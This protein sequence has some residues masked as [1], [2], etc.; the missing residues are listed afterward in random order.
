MV[1]NSIT[2]AVLKD[3]K[4]L[5]RIDVNCSVKNGKII[6][7]DRLKA[8]AETIKFLINKK[9]RVVVLAHQGSPDKD[10]FISLKQHSKILNKYVKLKFVSELVGEKS[11]QEINSLKSG[12]ALL[13]ENVRF[14][15]DE[16]KPSLNNS[17]SIFFKEVGFDYYVNDAFSVSHRNQTSI[18]SL[19]QIFPGLM[20]LNLEKEINNL[21]QLRKL[22]KSSLFILGGVKLEDI[23]LLLN[24][25]KILS[26]GRLA[27][28]AL[29]VKGYDLGKHNQVTKKE[30]D[31]VK[32]YIKNITLPLDLAI[33]FNG[34]RKEIDVKDLPANGKILDL[35]MKTLES[36]KKEITKSKAIFFKGA[37]GRIEQNGFDIG[38]RMI[39][40]AISNSK[41]FSVIS[42]GSSLDSLKKFKIDKRKFSYISLSGGALIHYVSGK[43]LP[44]LDI[45][46]PVENS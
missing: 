20:G 8:S 6:E 2:N 23:S 31:L 43:K 41:A 42:G 35:G 19:S 30:I 1:L 22:S 16:F 27:I 3:K 29:K 9:A 36:Y 39:L 11:W 45:L 44:G 5:L 28:V 12:E 37:V 17:I 4:I 10:D 26:T 32:P 24:K 13:L 21:N 7:N 33:D 40:Q 25:K 34:K 18:V 14:L 38:S 15:K 46:D